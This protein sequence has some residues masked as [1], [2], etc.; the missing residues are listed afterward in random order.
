[1]SV[2]TGKEH[3]PVSLQLS[4]PGESGMVEDSCGFPKSSSLINLRVCCN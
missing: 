1:M 4:Y 2:L 3:E